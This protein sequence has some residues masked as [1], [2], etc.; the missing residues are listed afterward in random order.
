MLVL[1]TLLTAERFPPEKYCMLRK[2]EIISFNSPHELD[3]RE[4]SR[5]PKMS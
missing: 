2:H 3:P 4:D 5:S 1:S